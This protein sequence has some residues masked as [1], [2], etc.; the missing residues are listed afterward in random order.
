MTT[1]YTDRVSVWYQFPN[2]IVCRSIWS[3]PPHSYYATCWWCLIY[4]RADEWWKWSESFS[5]VRTYSSTTIPC[6]TRPRI[7]FHSLVDIHLSTYP[8]LQKPPTTGTKYIMWQKPQQTKTKSKEMA[9]CW[10]ASDVLV[11]YRRIYLSDSNVAWTRFRINLRNYR[12]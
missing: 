7:S 9:K 8:L 11:L 5:S 2:E 10:H 12:E 1:Q 3:N 4:L 6:R